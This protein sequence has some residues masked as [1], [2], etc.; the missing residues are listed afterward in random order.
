[1]NGF[2][3]DTSVAIGW[4]LPETFAPAARVWQQK[5]LAHEAYAAHLEA[6][7][8]P[9]V[10][11]W[12]NR[13]AQDRR[14]CRH[15]PRADLAAQHQGSQGILAAAHL[16]ASI[17]NAAPMELVTGIDWRDDIPHPCASKT[18][19]C[20]CPTSPDLGRI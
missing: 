17:P 13:G 9:D 4:Y 3:L 16:M 1:V 8:R 7:T 11:R 2:V 10:R 14:H 20:G 5:L 15:L 12:H 18:A 6:P 19:P